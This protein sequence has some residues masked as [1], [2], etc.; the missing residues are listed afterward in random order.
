MWLWGLSRFDL[1]LSYPFVGLS[2]VFTLAFGY[3]L[4]GES[5]NGWRLAGTIFIVIGCAFVAKS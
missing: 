3:A 1:G 5:V 2:F 4:L